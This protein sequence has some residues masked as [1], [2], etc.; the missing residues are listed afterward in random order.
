MHDVVGFAVAVILFEG[1]LNLNVGR[2]RRE[3]L[4]IRRLLTLGA[5]VTLAGATLVSHWLLGWSWSLAILFG[6]LVIVTGPTVITPLLRRIR[7]H[8]T[9]ETI[10]EAEGVFVDAIGAIL[11]IVVLEVVVQGPTR[12]SLAQG[13]MNPPLRLAAGALLGLVGG[14]ILTFL[15]RVRH[16][17]PEGF[18]NTFSL[19][20]AIALFHLSNLWVP[21]TGI[22]AVIVAG[23][24][25]GNTTAAPPLRELKEFKEQLT[26]LLIGLLFVLL[27]ADVALDDI[28][29]LGLAG[30]LVVLTLMLLIRPLS[31]VLSTRGSDLDWRQK[32]FLSWVA[33]RGIVA[34]AIGSLFADRLADAGI[35]GGEELKALVFLVIAGTVVLQGASASTV[36]GWLGLRRPSN[37]GYAIL[38]ANAFA[39]LFARRLKAGGH[40]VIMMDAN[41]D[42]T[43][44]AQ[45]EGLSVVFGN[46]LEERAMLSAQLE[47][48]RGIVG[49]LANPAQNLLF[50]QAGRDEGGAPQAWVA[51]QRGPGVPDENAVT[52]SGTHL[53]FGEA[54]DLEL[55]SVRIRREL[56]RLE[57]WEWEKTKEGSAESDWRIPRES[58]NQLLPFFLVRG[59]QLH[60][61][62]ETT[63]LKTGDRVEW[64]I[65]VE[66]AESAHAHLVE[67][68]WR[69]EVSTLGDAED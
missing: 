53:L 13:F 68:G 5:A 63:R 29:M 30:V 54:Q 25:V 35:P 22:S 37:Q 65:L 64:L 14:G 31:V 60:L 18:Q 16:L 20:W 42:S 38:G 15:L 6:S 69:P 17:V 32:A 24:L 47:S 9:L 8:R 41:Q 43:E 49:L 39:R 58:R 7:V 26:V 62:D 67:Q 3:A 27:A 21:E 45:A 44:K 19:A 36:A 2:L 34:A 56:T 59:G 61:I 12:E 4:P 46:A 23:L 40:D 33:P 57:V 10:L 55:W 1:G 51:V 48:R 11:A 28:R 52:E 66:A 50:A